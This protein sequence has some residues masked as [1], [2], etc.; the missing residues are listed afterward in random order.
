MT[1]DHKQPMRIAPKGM[2]KV[3]GLASGDKSQITGVACANAAGHAL[4]PMVIFKV[5]QSQVVSR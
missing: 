1:L 4:P 5:I 2:R 3:H